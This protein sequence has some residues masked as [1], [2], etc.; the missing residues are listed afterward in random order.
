MCAGEL[1]HHKATQITRQEQELHVAL[2][3]GR[4]RT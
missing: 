2:W 4:G 3:R 1:Q